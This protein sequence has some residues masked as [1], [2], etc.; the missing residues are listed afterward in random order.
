MIFW[1][2]VGLTT[3]FIFVLVFFRKD[4]HPTLWFYYF[5]SRV[6][7]LLDSEMSLQ[8]IS[9]SKQWASITLPIS[10]TDYYHR[11]AIKQ[12]AGRRLCVCKFWCCAKLN[13]SP[14]SPA[15]CCPGD[16]NNDTFMLKV[17]LLIGAL[18]YVYAWIS[19]GEC[20][21]GYQR[22]WTSELVSCLTMTKI[23]SRNM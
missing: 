15:L 14:F 10:L 3:A 1:A 2:L 23:D 13:D 20:R 9:R 5:L 6:K 16:C 19:C 7:R 21:E 18:G 22:G 17:N 11:R 12:H 8:I 4:N